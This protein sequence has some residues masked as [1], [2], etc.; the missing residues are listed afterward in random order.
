MKVA[1]YHY[2]FSFKRGNYFNTS[3]TLEDMYPKLFCGSGTCLFDGDY[4]VSFICTPAQARNIR[5]YINR[6][7][8]KA[9]M[10]RSEA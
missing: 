5:R 9:K 7:L 10:Y 2:S 4:D 6:N 1:K 3:R 8:P